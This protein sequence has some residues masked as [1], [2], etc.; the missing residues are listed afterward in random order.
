MGKRPDFYSNVTASLRD[1]YGSFM[2]SL[3]PSVILPS[4]KAD[5]AWSSA[6]VVHSWGVRDSQ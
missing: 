1:F 2:I 4:V 5:D 3:P 6:P